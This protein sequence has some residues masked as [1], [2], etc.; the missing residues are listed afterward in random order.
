M[1]VA[2]NDLKG[3][4]PDIL[5]QLK[6][7]GISQNE[8][9]LEATKSPEERKSLAAKL[10]IETRPLLEL[11]N[12]ADLSRIKGVAGV[13][14]DLLEQAGV[15]T[16]KELATRRPDNLHAKMVEVNQAKNLTARLPTQEMIESWVAQAKEL[17]KLLTY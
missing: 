9:L 11:A 10:G 15:D 13:Y 16:V 14:S 17:P 5:K 12:R 2:I 8:Q 4:T 7:L 6:E 1:S 3:M